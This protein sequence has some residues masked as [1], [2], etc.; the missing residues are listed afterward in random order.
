MIRD[1]LVVV[2]KE[3]G[4]TSFD[5]VA[6]LRRILGTKKAGHTGTL[7]PEAQ[8]VL[9]V[10]FGKGTKV[11]S[12]MEDWDKAYTAVLKL[13][14]I[15][16]TQDMTGNVLEERDYDHVSETMF[17]DTVLSFLGAQMQVPPM[18]SALKVQ[19]KKLYELA[20][21]GKEVER[22]ARPVH[23]YQLQVRS[24]TPPFAEISVVCSKGTYIRTL[25]H[26]IGEALG[27]GAAMESLVRTRVGPFEGGKAW[28]IGELEGAKE[29][30]TL[31]EYLLSLQELLA[32]YPA[33]TCDPE[34]DRYLMNGNPINGDPINGL[35]DACN[36]TGLVRMYTSE[37]AFVGLY[38]W[39]PAVHKYRPEKMFI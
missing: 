17:T 38:Q 15:T 12:L 34:Q 21:E 14:V 11:I 22:N 25:C 24:F 8:G 32:P 6:K 33:Y 10:A 4:W 5:V 23:F 39:D 20:R 13:G 30:G 7:D 16:D 31:D 18:Y 28:R 29:A 35:K 36:H 9:P 1:G 37:G 3:A 26:D 2:W 27:C 19:G